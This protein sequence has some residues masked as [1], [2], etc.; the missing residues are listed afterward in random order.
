MNRQFSDYSHEDENVN[1]VI[2]HVIRQ[3]GTVAYRGMSAT[4]GKK[5]FSW[6]YEKAMAQ[7]SEGKLRQI[8]KALEDKSDETA[9]MVKKQ[10]IVKEE[11]KGV[12]RESA[13]AAMRNMLR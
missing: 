10:E 12:K 9:E 2:R 8:P 4:D 7:F 3:I 13:F 6:N 11:F 1:L 5:A